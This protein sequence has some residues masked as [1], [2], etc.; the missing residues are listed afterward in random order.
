MCLYQE[1][2]ERV[3]VEHLF[4][5]DAAPGLAAG[6]VG[7]PEL[8]IDAFLASCRERGMPGSLILLPLFH[9]SE[10]LG[11]VICRVSVPDGALYESLVSQISNAIKGAALVSAVRS[12]SEEL[13]RKVA[14]RSAELKT[15]LE[16]L[17]HANRRLEALSVRD[18]LTGLYNRRGFLAGSR[19]YF[20]LARRREGEFLLFYVD[21]DGLKEINDSFG[22]LNG[23]DAL[24]N[25]SS[26]LAKA[27]R[28]TDILAR[29][30]GDEFVVFAVDMK[31]GQEHVVRKRLSTIVDDFNATSGKP[32]VLA[33][34]MGCAA[35]Q[36]S[37]YG[38]LEEIMDEADRR[39]YAEKRNKKAA[40]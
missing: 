15:A 29:M 6:A 36:P 16:D 1:T 3:R 31:P 9:R 25:M 34:S 18:E 24:R 10:D 12:H 19:Q 13:E 28:Q 2:T 38:S 37:L 21:I 8:I 27:F 23:D 33:Y 11:F 35:W 4:S 30:G 26:L 17:E 40:G 39:L 20:D 7:A 14:Q 22:H 32:Y 5:V